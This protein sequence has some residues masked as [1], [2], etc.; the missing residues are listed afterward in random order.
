MTSNEHIY[1]YQFSPAED[2]VTRK[3]WIEVK[4]A[5]RQ[6]LKADRSDEQKFELVEKVPLKTGENFKLGLRRVHNKY[7]VV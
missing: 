5:L 1:K 7:G 4:R 6:E 3:Q 2:P